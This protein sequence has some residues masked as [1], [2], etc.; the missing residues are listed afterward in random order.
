MRVVR[1]EGGRAVTGGRELVRPGA[2]TWIDAQPT[3]EEI[4]FIGEK[5]RFHPLA[6]EDA[7]HQ[8]QRPKLE[9]YGPGM[10]L[11]VVHRLQPSPDDTELL[12]LEL[13]AFLTAE[14]LVTFHEA[15][16]AEVDRVFARCCAEPEVL[17]RGPDFALY[18]LYDALTDIHYALVDALTGEIEEIFDEV[19]AHERA[20]DPE[21]LARI[22]SARRAHAML[23]RRLSPQR[24]VFAALARPGQAI[25]KD[26]SALYFR[27]VVDHSVR[28][29][30]EIDTGRDLLASAMD[31][32]LSHNNNRLSAV[33]ARLTLIST[34]FLPLNFI[35]GF[36]GMNLEIIHPRVAIPFVLLA[37]ITLPTTMWVTFKRKRLL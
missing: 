14:T 33:T 20:E 25:V 29:T 13:D 22:V 2:I 21:Q 17:A 18:L 8:D 35:A 19:A 1:L 37:V 31:A 15:P 30:D 7:A 11:A 9:Q 5:F 12:A 28:L 32:H 24:E 34:I 10:L 23:R 26:Q 16:I 3:P 27:D 4:A 36:F 6:L